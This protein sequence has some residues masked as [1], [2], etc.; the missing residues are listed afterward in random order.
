MKE[1]SYLSRSDISKGARKVSREKSKKPLIDVEQLLDKSEIKYIEV[2]DNVEQNN[3]D[4]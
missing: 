2:V 4:R 3:E 1:D